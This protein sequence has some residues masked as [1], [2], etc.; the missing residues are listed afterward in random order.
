M[1]L[2]ETST[3]WNWI[4]SNNLMTLSVHRQVSE[5]GVSKSIVHVIKHANFQHHGVNPDGVI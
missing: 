5:N 2:N 4:N 1:K 3:K